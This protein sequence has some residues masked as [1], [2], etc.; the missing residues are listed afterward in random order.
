MRAKDDETTERRVVEIAWLPRTPAEWA[1]FTA[2][3]L[4]AAKLRNAMVRLHARIRRLKWKWPSYVRFDKW[5]RGKFPAISAHSVQQI[6]RDFCDT[7]AATTKLR[8]KERAA[9][10]EPTARYPWRTSRYRD[11]IYAN[12]DAVVRNG[13]L[14]LPHGRHGG[15]LRIRM[16][17]SLVL[18]GRIMQATL[19]YGFVRIVCEVPA[20]RSSTNAPMVGVDL[21]VNTLLAATD[22]VAAVLVSGREAKAIVRYRNKAGAEL[23]SRIG[24]CERGSKRRKRFVRAKH[25][26]LD[27]SVRKLRDLLHRATRAVANAFP[28]HRVVVG[29][30][31]NDAARKM[32]RVQAQQVSQASNARLIAQLS[33]K[34]AGATEV[35]E[36]Y[37][38]QTCPGCGCRQKCRRAYRCAECGWSAPRD[39]VGSVNIRCIGL[40]GEMKPD[41]P[42][43]TRVIF[44]RPLRKYPATFLRENAAGRPGGTPAATRAA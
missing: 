17:H 27:K 8:K 3:R 26:M 15:K 20:A 35:P 32:G 38:S 23:A 16:P 4:E 5:A 7:I 13:V 36:P 28:D 12:D 21:G 6:V 18:P 25:R 40:Y 37:S 2:A 11:V 39:V 41:Q 43:P 1:V 30:P 14:T 10:R 42:V 19:A 9:R 33:Y 34:M 31:F 29:K 24:C 22:G 44:I